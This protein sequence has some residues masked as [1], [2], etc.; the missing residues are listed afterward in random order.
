M[1]RIKRSFGMFS[2][3]LALAALGGCMTDEDPDGSSFSLSAETEVL[4]IVEP[5]ED[6]GEPGIITTL[7]TD[8]ECEDGELV[9]DEYE[10]DMYYAITGG[11][12]YLWYAG[13]CSAIKLT[14]SSSDITG[15]W[16]SSNLSTR[17]PSAYRPYN[18]D[19]SPEDSYLEEFLNDASITYTIS[20][21]EIKGK[22][23]G[24]FC[25]APLVAEAYENNQDIEVTSSSCSTVKL[26]NEDVNRTATIS[27]SYNSKKDEVTRT[28]AYNG[29]KCSLTTSFGLSSEPPTCS[30]DAEEEAEEQMDAYLECI[31]DSEFVEDFGYGGI[32]N[33]G[34]GGL[35]AV[36][37]KALKRARPF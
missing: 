28:I 32:L 18:C 29:K 17:I 9:E 25:M 8:Y 1:A 14:G 3:F 26:K 36:F 24:T 23:T 20:A 30:E 31:E 21:S 19:Y 37:E 7:S 15:T 10:D 34:Q 11:S 22:V 13:D 27:A 4:D 35:P 33:K 2:G 5:D 12:L 16:K 6:S